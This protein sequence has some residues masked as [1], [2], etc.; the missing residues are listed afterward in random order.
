[1]HD[2]HFHNI[3]KRRYWLRRLEFILFSIPVVFV[4]C[5]IFNLLLGGSDDI[6]CRTVQCAFPLWL[7]IAA[8]VII[9]LP[10]KFIRSKTLLVA[11]FFVLLCVGIIV[12]VRFEPEGDAGFWEKV[13]LPFNSTL[14][15]FFPSRGSYEYP[16]SDNPQD[17]NW[18]IGY[19]VFHTALYFYA[20]WL[21][22]SLFGRKLLNRVTISIFIRNRN[23]NLIW[24]YSEAAME[25]AMD[26]IRHTEKDEPIFILDDDIEF[27]TER[28]KRIFDKLSNETILAVN[29]HYDDLL[30]FGG[31]FNGGGKKW[32]LSL[33]TNRYFNGYRHYFITENQDFNVKYALIVLEQLSFQRDKLRG[34]THLYVR[35]EQ[36][37]IDV[38]FQERLD[39]EL[40]QKVEV[41]IFNQ[42]DITARL[43]VEQHPILDL[44]ERAIPG[45]DK[46][47]LTINHESLQVEGEVNILLLGFGWTGLEMLRKEVS[48]AQFIGSYKLNVVVVDNDYKHLH[49]R[50]QFVAR[51]AARFGVNICINP[52][53]W[54]D[55]MHTIKK[56]WIG[57]EKCGKEQGLEE[58][59]IC[60][61]NGHLFYEWLTFK[62]S[63]I[64]IENILHFNRIIVALGSDELNVNT[65][66]QLATFRCRYL[67]ARETIRPSLM[68]EP[69]F[70]HVRDKERYSYYERHRNSPICIFGGLKNIYTVA[71]LVDEKMDVVAKLVNY[72]YSRYD[73]VQLSE[74][75]LQKSLADGSAETAW[76]KCSI[77]DQDSSRAV[78]MNIRNVAT[79]TG[80][81]A[82]LTEI[83]NDE[84]Y[85]ELLSEM[86]HM[87]WNAFHYMRGISAWDIDEVVQARDPRGKV[88][89]NGKLSFNGF[90]T[91]HI[92]LVDYDHLDDATQKV[93]ALGNASEN[94][95]GSDRRIIRHF[96]VF[97]RIKNNH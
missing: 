62:D 37:G 73:K 34:K 76:A 51:E 3:R 14:G 17:K 83:V 50:Y 89:A 97:C 46:K 80:G 25:F 33:P 36:Q 71:N 64:G 54:L 42:S 61:A 74:E 41:H 88:K 75:E 5:L 4:F 8:G 26:M 15:S 30:R 16:D 49:G 55:D 60:Q 65:A 29:V 1:M 92:C 87:R 95:K 53:V 67:G 20:A 43:F 86:E 94:F 35:T 23:K 96:P 77:F 69:V 63:E 70:A 68:P 11:M 47:W 72:V 13:F 45:T 38:F 10:Q 48:D 28:E 21:G 91:R 93:R 90:L 9:T 2:K 24:G 78:A 57:S 6:L 40:S 39:E 52:V 66:L 19:L 44:A 58:K 84:R 81:A 12:D 18:I 27:D 32:R 79:I 82:R 31:N 22:F 59:R 56:Q 85:I 7:V